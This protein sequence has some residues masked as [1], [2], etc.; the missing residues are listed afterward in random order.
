M[1]KNV[2]AVYST[3]IRTFR[4]WVSSHNHKTRAPA[5]QLILYLDKN[6]S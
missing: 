3:G 6:G 4:M 2:H 5:R 1:C